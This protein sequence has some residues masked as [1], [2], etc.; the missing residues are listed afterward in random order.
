MP[1]GNRG[2]RIALLVAL[3]AGLS[4]P[5][6]HAAPTSRH[7]TA[8]GLDI[9][10]QAGS[11][12]DGSQLAALQVDQGPPEADLPDAWAAHLF[13]D[14]LGPLGPSTEEIEDRLNNVQ[15]DGGLVQDIECAFYVRTPRGLELGKDCYNPCDDQNPPPECRDGD[16]S[17]CD[18]RRHLYC[19][20]SKTMGM[21]VVVADPTGGGS[22]NG[23][24]GPGGGGTGTGTHNGA[25]D[26]GGPDRSDDA[27]H[28]A[29][30]Q[31]GVHA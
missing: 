19:W 7:T 12:P 23:D 30:A 13:E 29:H 11:L 14:P 18:A 16:D 22:G 4:A 8:E 28:N 9:T 3:A 2:I 5:A 31:G 24:G 21:T 20:E 27:T 10:T 1:L 26:R 6:V 17:D 25:P 15:S